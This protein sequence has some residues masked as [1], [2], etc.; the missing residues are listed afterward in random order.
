MKSKWH[1][2]KLMHRNGLTFKQY[3]KVPDDFYGGI[4]SDKIVIGN[5]FENS[6]M[7]IKRSNND[8][9]SSTSED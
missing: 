2:W 7:L 3:V 8:R 6:E 9:H 1:R 5:I 4:S